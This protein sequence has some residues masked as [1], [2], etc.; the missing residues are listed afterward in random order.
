[1]ALGPGS[2]A[3]VGINT[4][5]TDW[6]AFVAI[7]PIPAGQVIYFT[8]NELPSAG[9]T[10]FNTGESYTKWVAPAE[11]VAAGTVV[12]FSSFYGTPGVVVTNVGSA[13]PVTFAGSANTGLSTTQDSVYAYLAAG[14]GSVDTPLTHLAFVNI[15][16]SIDPAPS[17]LASND[18]IAF[19]T[20][21]DSAYYTGSHSDQTTF[22]GYLNEIS[23]PANWTL[24]AG[25][26]DNSTLNAS[27]FVLD[28]P[29][30]LSSSTP[31]DNATNVSPASDI[32][33]TFNENVH[34]GTGNIVIKNVSDN[35]VVQTV[36]VT[37]ASEVTISG[38]TVT[39]NP[40]ADLAPN[41][42]YYVEM[43]SG[44]IKDSTN[45]D[46]A[47][48][49]GPAALNFTTAAS[50][51]QAVS[52]SAGSLAVSHHEGQSGTTDY[53]FTVERSGGTTGDVNFSGTFASANT[54]DADY[55]GG[56]P[57]SFSGA[58]LAGDTS[59]DVTIHVAGD[60]TV[61]D[62]E[63]FGLTLNSVSNSDSTIAV[64][65]GSDVNATGT[66]Q[67][68]DGFIVHTGQTLTEPQTLGD[69]NSGIVETGGALAVSSTASIVAVTWTGG[70]V[71]IDN[72]GTISATSTGNSRA[73]DTGSSVLAGGSSLTVTNHTG[74]EIV[75]ATN[76]AFRINSDMTN[77]NIEIDNSGFIV[78]GQVDALG[79]ISGTVGGQGLDFNNIASASNHTTIN[80]F[81]GGLIGA[82][83][84]DGIRPG[85]NATINNYGEIIGKD[86]E[87]A[88]TKSDG[89]D[90]QT[91]EGIIVHNFSGGSI[92]GARHGMTGNFPIAVTNDAGAIITGEGGS[93]LNMDTTPLSVDVV[94]NYG[95]ITGTAVNGNDGD[96]IDTDGLIQLDNY[97]TV[98]AIGHSAGIINEGLAIGGGT[99]NNFAGGVIHS[100]ER[101]ITSDDS[102][103]GNAFGATTIYNEGTI[104]GD[105]GEAIAITDIFADT[106]TNKGVIL[107]SVATG[108]G[109]DVLNLYTG[110][111]ISGGIDGGDGTDTVNLLG[112]GVGTLSALTN[113]EFVE[114]ES[115]D[116]S[117]TNESSA[118]IDFHDGA[119]ILRIANAL[120]T[121]GAFSDTV[122]G[123]GSGDTIDLDGI[124]LATSAVLGAGNV[125]TILGGN[126]GPI[127]LQLDPTQDFSGEAFRLASDT[128]AGS[129]LTVSVDQAPVFTSPAAVSVAENTTAVE[130]VTA[131]DPENDAFL[132]ALAGGDDK[133][134]FAIDP[135]TGALHFLNSPDF[136]TPQDTNHDNV[137]NVTV[138][139]TDSFG[140]V[141]T[142][143]IAISVTDVAETGHFVS[144]GNGG[145][146]LIGTTGNDTLNGGNGND[147]LN[148]TDGNDI[149]LG[150]NGND[151]LTGGRGDDLLNGGDG[152][153]NLDGGIGNDNLSGDNGADGLNGGNGDDVL[154]GGNGNDTLDGG[155][156]NDSL[157]GDEGNDSL[158]GGIGND[159]LSGGAG[160]DV[161][162][163]T[164]GNNTLDGGL[165]NDSL[166][167]GDGDD[168]LSGGAGND[169]VIA[170]GG[171]DTITGGDGKDVLTGGAGADF[172]VFGIVTTASADRI[173]DFVAGQDHLQFTAANFGLPTGT[174]DAAHLV[175][176]AAAV[177]HHAEFVYNPGSQKLLWDAD[178]VGGT[179]AVT[180]ATFDSAVALTHA[181]LLLV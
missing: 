17:S 175:F 58:I 176:G 77:G 91:N 8:D 60:T 31:A 94:T 65:L 138:S 98:R 113:F 139:A 115:G 30:T 50:E 83:A 108:D 11:G 86:G 147:Q 166:T 32:V 76:D 168:S 84:E 163:D 129:L 120:L 90:G 80:N 177:D 51:S 33:L 13:S 122:D 6:F 123:F 137:Y 52:F 68:D 173:V 174:L 55:T 61:E 16:T 71:N 81:A 145:D 1:M 125:L 4:N 3:F 144:G 39:I 54:D 19:N 12:N 40:P 165:G 140:A 14:D 62:D 78:S 143:S 96:G 92:I 159:N 171:N 56:K 25:A 146:I 110:S 22:A 119:Q 181:D 93:G 26:T 28:T 172:F 180:V 150:G 158:T 35:S 167:A 47:G 102:D 59:A 134:F 156:G 131:A 29:P 132:F 111:S 157:S 135:S 141:S 34:A 97:G 136:E 133:A 118:I 99:V 88:A 130:T 154:A 142:Q 161:L 162:S 149:L 112:T 74:A 101:A 170:G 82:A 53:V 37:N 9:A 27:P 49:S 21:S 10:T 85:A 152:N 116:W 57:V 45:N 46:F 87:G 117:V 42:A 169:T 67:N 153:D 7:D 48:I 43:A 179:A 79:N 75:A 103:L 151:L 95:T 69:G 63:S 72:A 114:L 124:G 41:T 107:G 38:A 126:S 127:T 89:I 70:T 148:G 15:G 155:D 160:N 24:G 121:D 105:S 109:D 64:A 73:I 100:D 23:N 2:I 44:V 5:G 178:G 36:D 106:L 66:I 20:A 18:K 164:S 128:T 104:Q